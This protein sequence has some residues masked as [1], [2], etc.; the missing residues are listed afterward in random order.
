MF[1]NT[2]L[3][4]P[5]CGSSDAM[6]QNDDGWGHCFACNTRIPPVAN[7]TPAQETSPA[8]SPNNTPFLSGDFYPLKRRGIH[9]DTCQKYSYR[10]MYIGE[11]PVQ[12]ADYFDA[13]G[14]LVAQHLRY[15]DKTF[16]WV[17]NNKKALMFGQHLWAPKG[18]RLVIT[19]GELDCLSV[20]QA[21]GNKWPVVSIPSGAQSAA[22][23]IKR[24]LEFIE[25]FN[26]VILAFDDDE[27]GRE[28]IQKVAT[29][30][31]PGKVKVMKYN[32]LKDANDLLLQKG[33]DAVASCVFQAATYRPDGILSGEE[34]WDIILKEPEKGLSI[35]YSKLND[36]LMGVMPG[37]LY[38]FTAGSGIGK[39]TL[40]HELGY[41]LMMKHNQSIGV[42][43]LEESVK[44]AAERYLSIYLD[45]PL[46]IDRD[47]S[48]EKFREAYEKSVGNKRFWI[49]NHF[50]S[51]QMENLMSKL[52][53]MAV[54]LG[55][56]WII[57]DHISIVVSG[58]DEIKDDERKLIDKL[59][60]NLRT[61]VEN[62]GIG[63]LAVVH[64]KRP[65]RGRSY[66]EGRQVAL[67]DLRGSASLEQL[68]DAVIAVERNQQD[69]Q[70]KNFTQVRVL[71]NRRVGI[72]GEADVL[73]YVSGTGRLIES[74]MPEEGMGFK[75]ETLNTQ[76][77]F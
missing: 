76:T 52:R 35:P 58:L 70:L 51:T 43:A 11:T 25:G 9:I 60:T 18:K 8:C 64:L 73:E 41:H 59:M 54:G 38:M 10:G 7:S 66:N 20:A 48:K 53:Y 45:K 24:S 17:G 47:V 31:T 44:L 21:F 14:N 50:G 75:N 22:S 56:K 74:K 32:G 28:A 33:P 67:T 39:S 57:L 30:I 36:M 4:C 71:K 16:P 63:M 61:L 1:S 40:V 46:R 69:N 27:A 13:D 5:K 37:E 55:V 23:A 62:T 2:H 65:D 68:S 49:Y 34:L 42:M 77:D 3:P 29:L 26:E 12:I 72:T 6:S 19:E 15:P